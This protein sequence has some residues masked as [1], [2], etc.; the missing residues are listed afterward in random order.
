MIHYRSAPSIAFTTST[1][2]TLTVH[3]RRNRSITFSL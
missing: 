1:V 3:T 2:R